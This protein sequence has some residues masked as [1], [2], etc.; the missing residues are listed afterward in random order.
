MFVSLEKAPFNGEEEFEVAAVS[1]EVLSITDAGMTKSVL[2]VV[3]V[4]DFL[5]ASGSV[6][7]SWGGEALEPEAES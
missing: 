4:D 3:S 2:G 6:G 1:G 7:E 5:E